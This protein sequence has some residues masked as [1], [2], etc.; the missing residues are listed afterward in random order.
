MC[1]KSNNLIRVSEIRENDEV[2]VR[3]VSEITV[4]HEECVIEVC[5]RS[6]WYDCVIGVCDKN[7]W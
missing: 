4:C 5:D 6:V 2:C 7:V 3:K 1:D